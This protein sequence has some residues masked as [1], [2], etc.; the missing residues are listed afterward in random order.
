MLANFSF[1]FDPLLAVPKYRQFANALA[2]HLTASKFPAGTKLPNDRELSRQYAI[3]KVTVSKALGVL[4][5]KGILERRV[6]AGTFTSF[7]SR[8]NSCRIA[9]VCHGT[10]SIDNG[11]VSNLWDELHK[12]AAEYQVDLLILQRSP[13]EYLRAVNSYNLD[14][15]IVLSAEKEF[16]P[17][18]QELA[19]KK[20]A[21][22]QVGMFHPEC[23]EISFGTDH[24]Q[25]A[26][27][28]VNF[29]Y[30]LG[31]REIGFIMLTIH[32]QPHFSSGE[33]L[34]GY[35]RAMYENSL[36]FNPRWLIKSGRNMKNVGEEIYKLHDQG[37]LPTAFIL[38]NVGMAPKVGYILH[39]I[40]RSIPEDISIIGFDPAPSGE[41]FLPGLTCFSHDTGVLVSKV[42]DHLCHRK[43]HDGQPLPLI[44]TER[45]SCAK[46]KT[47]IVS[48]DISTNQRKD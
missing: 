22:A 35:L 13:K 18:L 1:S 38:D 2:E 7:G 15:L 14:G 44:L 48:S 32:G 40:G 21:I 26:G 46:V 11:F 33:R 4:E 9:L 42:F 16:L 29:L 10:I 34:Y 39:T 12:Q 31:H 37:E 36:P 5:K 43:K 28:A 47:D 19:E 17:E 41:Q 8:Q 45:G 25:A 30:S 3:A 23:K 20:I 27:K 24:A 6:G